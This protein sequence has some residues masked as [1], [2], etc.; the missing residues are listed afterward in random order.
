MQ[1]LTATAQQPSGMAAERQRQQALLTA[2]RAAQHDPGMHSLHQLL[3]LW[4]E[5]AKSTLLQ[6]PHDEFLGAQARACV[7]RNLLRDVFNDN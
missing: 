6:C 2:A 5:E 3:H 1:P 7:Y 4:L